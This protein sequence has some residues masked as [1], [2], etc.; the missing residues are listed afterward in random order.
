ML[1]IE[2]VVSRGDRLS[3]RNGEKGERENEKV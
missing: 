1:H 3:E 2:I